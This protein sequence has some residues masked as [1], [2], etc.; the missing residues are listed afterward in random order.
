MQ[1][2]SSNKAIR[3]TSQATIVQPSITTT[4]PLKST[5]KTQPFIS[6]AHYAILI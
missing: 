6:T 5:P 1:T 3:P 4:E 2:S